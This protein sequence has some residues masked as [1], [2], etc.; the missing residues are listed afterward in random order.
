MKGVTKL[1]T[2]TPQEARDIITI[3]QEL[4]KSKY[5]DAV[6]KVYA[7]IEQG[8]QI[9]DLYEVFA[10]TG[11]DDNG[12]PK[13]AI[14]RADRKEIYLTSYGNFQYRELK[15]HKHYH[16]RTWVSKLDFSLPRGTFTHLRKF[17]RNKRYKTK[18]PTIPVKIHPT[19]SLKKYYIL[20]EVESWEEIDVMPTD[21]FLLKRLTKNLF[22]IVAEWD[23]TPLEQAIMKGI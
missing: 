5:I 8:M 1:Q 11:T 4:P 14:A 10:K 3:A 19:D 9:L 15:K 21:P 16:W 17:E 18:V 23:L 20:W 2:V 6:K 22:G 7:C 12:L 13:L